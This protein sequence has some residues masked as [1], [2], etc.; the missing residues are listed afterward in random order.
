MYIPLYVKTN[1]SLLSSL[2]TIDDLLAFC[3]KN[4]WTTLPI[5]DNNMYGAMEF[6]HKCQ[7]NNIKPVLG[8]ELNLEEG[9]LLLY[10][11]N[12]IGYQTLIQLTTIQSERKV[13]LADFT[14]R[15]QEVIA[16]VPEMNTSLFQSLEKIFEDLYLG[17]STSIEEEQAKEYTE[18]LVYVKKALYIKPEEKEYLDYLYMI[19]EGKTVADEIP[20][21]EEDF[22]LTSPPPRNLSNKVLYQ[23]QAILDACNVEFPKPELHL[24]KY[25]CENG[26]NEDQYLMELSKAGL[27]R[28]LSNQ[29][30]EA[31]QKRLYYELDI[32]RRMG[33]SN[34][35]LVVYDFIKY[36]KKKK[37]LVGPGRGSAAGSLVSYSLGITDIDPLKYNLLFERFLNPERVTMPD[38]D[39]DFPDAYR[40]EIIQ[41]VISKYGLKNVAGIITFGTLGVKQAIRDVSRVLNIP[42][43]KVDALCKLI[44]TVTHKKLSDFYQQDAAFRA[45]IDNDA[46]LLKMYQIASVIEGFPRHTSIHAAGIVMC[47]E[48]LD[49][50]I[51]LEKSD[52][53][54]LS[55]FSME[56][57]EELGLLKMDFLGL[58]NL[59][60]IM[61]I[62]QDIEKNTQ[63]AL[64]FN[65]IPMNDEEAL[66]IFTTA[67]TS[68]IFQFESAGMRNFLRKL[69]PTTFEDIFAA[70]ALFRPGPAVNIDSYIRRKHG[71]EAI[72]YLDPVLKPILE[73]TYG[74]LIYQEQIMQVAN[75]LAGYSLGEADILRR[76]MSKKKVDLIKNEEEKF[77]KQSIERGHEESTVRSIFQLILNFAGYGFNRSHSVAYA[78]IAYKMAYLK[79]KY[80]KYFF[81][82]LLSSVIGSDIK[83][84]EYLKEAKANHITVL[85]P[86]IKESGVTFV[87]KDEGI[88]FPLSN[89]R[90]IG[91]VAGN[92][93]MKERA[94]AP[95]TDLF[96]T[97]SRIY[98]RNVG[99]KNLEALIL[100][101]SFA[102]FGYNKRTLI[103][104]LDNLINYAEL[105]KD[106]DPSLVM[107]PEIEVVDEYPKE[108]LLQQ[109]KELFGFYMTAHPVTAYLAK[110][111]APTF[112]NEFTQNFGKKVTVLALVDNIK[113]IQTKN[114]E[115]MAF[116]TGS[117]ET[118]S[119]DIVLFPKIYQMYDTIQVGDI[120]K[121]TG[122]IERRLDKEQLVAKKIEWLSRKEEEQNL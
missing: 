30:P 98:S 33:F 107:K 111:E 32:I 26:M 45:K 27:L 2:I 18:K 7:K 100:S 56:Y 52:T 14:D 108:V 63:V 113:K 88:L 81:G 53:M 99:K 20:L 1:Y 19:K 4:N 58:K 66:H 43:Y 57:L 115:T 3:Q 6:F 104:N 24:P 9:P 109:E 22:S 77:V 82:G 95:F 21:V 116:I 36:A 47:E 11:K 90:G 25:P 49:H 121:I 93:I 78:I 91:L 72:T 12:Y 85:K 79:A 51:P 67:D 97:V 54:Y 74:I 44:P 75:V 34:Y 42:L 102:C 59:T 65:K 8:L 80:P 31:Y 110:E 70:I 5:T 17:I 86:N 13:E 15:N 62:L 118:T 29:V 55:G 35:F 71:Q 105:T 122:I 83:T 103:E 94:K 37:I 40:D 87:V 106:L 84:K 96:D 64:D 112:L 89:I 117:D 10:A 23:S 69:K 39:T 46:S 16:V 119:A 73:N 61:N 60:T 50:F 101:D 114:Q 92:E 120:L 28:R 76:A 38:I 41:Y 48:P 68:G